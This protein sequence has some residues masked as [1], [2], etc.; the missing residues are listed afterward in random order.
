MVE[1]L[2]KCRGEGG[3]WDPDC[4]ETLLTLLDEND[5]SCNDFDDGYYLGS[6]L[7]VLAS[8]LSGRGEGREEEVRALVRRIRRY[9]HLDEMHPSHE[10][11]LTC[12]CLQES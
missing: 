8:C 2:G 11:V 5:N 1:A 10:R 9:L 7:R 3:G 12:C 6:I 4:F